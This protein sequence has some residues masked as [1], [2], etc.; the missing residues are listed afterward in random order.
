V[1]ETLLQDPD[2]LELHHQIRT[3]I[4]LAIELVRSAIQH[5]LR[6]EI[7]FFDGW[8]LSEALVAEAVRR[9]KKWISPLK[10]NRNMETNSFQ[11]ECLQNGG[12]QRENLLDFQPH[13]AHPFFGKSS[14]GDQL[15]K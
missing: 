5:R 2:F 3:K 10:K 7:L 1:D 15:R 6:F 4:D 14:P 8:Y 9:R 13:R 11:R 12:G